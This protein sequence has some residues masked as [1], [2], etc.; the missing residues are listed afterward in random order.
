VV[1]QRGGSRGGATMVHNGSCEGL[2]MMAAS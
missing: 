2:A 1:H